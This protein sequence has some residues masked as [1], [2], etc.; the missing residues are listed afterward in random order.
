MS[1]SNTDIIPTN[2]FVGVCVRDLFSSNNFV[3]SIF[4]DCYMLFRGFPVHCP[5]DLIPLL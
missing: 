2:H 4:H 1:T 3:L 5:G